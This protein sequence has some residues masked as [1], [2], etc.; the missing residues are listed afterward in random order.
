MLNENT[1]NLLRNAS[2][3]FRFDFFSDIDRRKIAK[4]VIKYTKIENVS[5]SNEY[6]EPNTLTS[7]IRV[8]RNDAGGSK[9]TQFQVN[10]LPYFEA[11]DLAFKL[12]DIISLY[13]YTDDR[14]EVT[15]SIMIDS[16]E[17]G[18]P[19]ISDINTIKLLSSIDDCSIIEKKYRNDHESM[20]LNSLM[21]LYPNDM[22]TVKDVD[23]NNFIDYR[24][25]SMPNNRK[26]AVYWNDIKFDAVTVKFFIRKNYQ[27]KKKTFYQFVKRAVTSVGNILRNNGTFN[28]N[29]ADKISL[30]CSNQRKIMNGIWDYE[31]LRRNFP[32]IEV[33]VDLKLDES[34]LRSYY[35]EKIRPKLFTLISYGGFSSG[36]VNYDTTRDAFQVRD[37]VISECNNISGVEFFYSDIRGC[38]EN[39][40]F[41]ESEIR[42]SV[43]EKC[44]IMY[45]T[46][47]KDSKIYD[48]YFH[49]VG[50]GMEKCFVSNPDDKLVEAD[51]RKSVIRGPFN[52]SSF[53]DD[54]SEILKK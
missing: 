3:A 27:D 43:L 46:K 35:S 10:Y 34:I 53:I 9:M 7:M 4:N 1:I 11:L 6:K 24:H 41:Y 22:K 52:Y 5:F 17:I 51:V 42:S 48:S 39:C 29:E 54:D 33:M 38:F 47:L 31:T 18:L 13:G 19:K 37:A 15:V 23:P 16:K 40:V 32:K 50:I 12:F 20:Y 8:C 28:R 21:Y 44:E 49:G 26:F 45:G 25:Y 30:V 36:V 2:L 14:C